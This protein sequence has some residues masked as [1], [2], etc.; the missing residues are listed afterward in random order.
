MKRVAPSHH[1]ARLGHAKE[2]N[3][4]TEEIQHLAVKRGDLVKKQVKHA[5]HTLMFAIGM[6][7]HRSG[8]SC[9]GPCPCSA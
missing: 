9:F 6:G 1:G 8:P 7:E 4:C 3:Q 5:R 2:R